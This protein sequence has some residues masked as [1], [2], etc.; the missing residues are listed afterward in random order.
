MF[1]TLL[2][3]IKIKKKS[4]FWTAFN[5]FVPYIVMGQSWIKTTCS[6]K[7]KSYETSIFSLITPLTF[8][9]LP[10][11]KKFMKLLTLSN[12]QEEPTV[13]SSVMVFDWLEIALLCLAIL[14]QGCSSNFS[15]SL[16]IKL[17]IRFTCVFSRKIKYAWLP[18]WHLENTNI[19]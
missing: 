5:Y 11:N 9:S 13:T 7:H 12:L 15:R 1:F 6:N 3:N 19:I 2:K 4:N 17:I 14:I 18:L 16:L 8:S 10:S